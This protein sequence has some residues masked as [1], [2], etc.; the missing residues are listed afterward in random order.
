VFG[1]NPWKLAMVVDRVDGR[2]VLTVFVSVLEVILML[3]IHSMDFVWGV[4]VHRTLLN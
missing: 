3:S 1:G 4:G 2:V